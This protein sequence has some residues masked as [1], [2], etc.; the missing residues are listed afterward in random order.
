MFYFDKN[1]AVRY[2]VRSAVLMQY[3]WE[4]ILNGEEDVWK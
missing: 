1:I 2:G 3:V 4:N